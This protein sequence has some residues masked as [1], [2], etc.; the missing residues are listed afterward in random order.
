MLLAL[1]FPKFG[2]PA[3]AWIALA[4][5][6]VALAR[7][8]PGPARS[9]RREPLALGLATGVFYFGGTLYWLVD[10][11]ATYGDLSTPVAFGVAGL[12]VAYL[13]LFTGLFAVVM[14]AL[15][16]GMGRRALLLAPAVWVSTELAR[17]YVWDGFPWALLGSSQA[18]LLPVAQAA[19]LVGVYGV[20]F[21]V[22]AGSVAAAYLVTGRGVARTLVPA[23]ILCGLVVIAL[24]GRVRLEANV[25]VREGV[26]VTVGIA[27]GNFAQ[28]V[29]WEASEAQT[30]VDRYLRMTR[31]AAQRGASFVIWPESAV[32]F[33][34]KQSVARSEPIREAAR[35]D[36]VTLLV[37]GDEIEASPPGSGGP[38]V[39]L[40]NSAFLIRPDGE[41]GATYRKIHLVP[42]GEYV[43]LKRLLFFAEPLVRA[44]SDFSPGTVPVLL[45]VDGHPVSTAICYEV[46][47]PELNRRFVLD[48]SELLTTITND[49]WF[50]R[51]S[52]AYQ[53]FEQASLRAIEEGRYLVRAA[54]TGV[55]GVVDPYGRVLDRT[56]LFETTLIVRQVRFLKVRTVYSVIGDALGCLSVALTVGAL[57]AVWRQRV[58]ARRR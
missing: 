56:T 39:R 57:A 14:G 9:W 43:P 51:S 54:N 4:P 8:G 12:L 15:V 21:L 48:G 50:G 26:P 41:I 36:H 7:H 10:T 35:L 37:G 6:L 47:Y 34:F 45:P 42:F 53:H 31:E 25:L 58:A 44:V 32:P 24:W 30:I 22:V 28:D 23:G 19:S 5:L 49:A 18:P 20:S 2:H 40:Y 13:S 38:A 33:Y 52:A 11:M 46:V 1:S 17:T 55:S 27:Q 3:V 16:R 29:K